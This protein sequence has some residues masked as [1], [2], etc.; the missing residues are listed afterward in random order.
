MRSLI[1]QKI[2]QLMTQ[3]PLYQ[4]YMPGKIFLDLVNFVETA[5][6]TYEQQTEA[7][8]PQLPTHQQ[9]NHDFSRIMQSLDRK[10]MASQR[11]E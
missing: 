7:L 9:L 2:H 5:N 10:H 3:S 8:L 6:K 4:D 1:H 11:S